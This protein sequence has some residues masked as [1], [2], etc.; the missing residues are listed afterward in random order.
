VQFA[1]GNAVSP[2]IGA[3]IDQFVG[4]FYVASTDRDSLD[5]IASSYT[6]RS[7][8]DSVVLHHPGC[9]GETLRSLP[10]N[11]LTPRPAPVR[12]RRHRHGKLFG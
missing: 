2:Y 5:I 6:L 10:R 4:R 3:S 8:D 1:C 7:I 9:D 11:Q 12:E